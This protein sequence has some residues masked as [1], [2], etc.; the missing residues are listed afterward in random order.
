VLWLGCAALPEACLA[1]IQPSAVA[2]EAEAEP[3]AA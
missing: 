3:T 1:G 2:I